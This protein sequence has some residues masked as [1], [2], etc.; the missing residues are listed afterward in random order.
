[1]TRLSWSTPGT[2]FFEAGVD[3]GVL[4][5]GTV[6]VPWIGLISVDENPTG[7]DAKAYYI[8]GVKYL[9]AAANEEFAATLSAYTYPDEFNECDGSSKI[10]NGLYATQQARKTFSL[11]YRTRIGNDVDGVD[12]GYKIHLVYNALAAPSKATYS[13][14][15]GS[16][17]PSDFS[18]DITTRASAFALHRN[19]SHLVIDSTETD[20][21]ILSTLEDILYGSDT[22]ASRLP[23]ITELTSLFATVYGL[24]V[25]DNGDGT[26]TINAEDDALTMET[27]DVAQVN[28]PTV[29]SI[30]DDIYTISS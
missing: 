2:R 8:D 23:S 1:M 19:V 27:A 26:Y 12:H 3:Q 24:D 6:G 14:I 28:W 13:S 9:N 22:T 17:D 29:V 7:G 16:N 4:F 20:A 11:S 15:G 21:R 10:H 5:I 30:S 18:W 25:I